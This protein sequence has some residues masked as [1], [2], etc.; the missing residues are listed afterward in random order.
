MLFKFQ[1][2]DQKEPRFIKFENEFDYFQLLAQ[3]E[4]SKDSITNLDCTFEDYLQMLEDL[5]QKKIQ[6]RMIQ[7]ADKLLYYKKIILDITTYS[8]DTLDNFKKLFLWNCTS[9]KI[10]RNID[11]EVTTDNI[12]NFILKFIKGDILN[13]KN[14]I[15]E[16][17]LVYHINICIDV[18][19]YISIKSGFENGT[20][21][22]LNFEKCK[23]NLMAQMFMP[24][25]DFYLENVNSDSRDDN[26]YKIKFINFIGSL[27]KNVF[28]FKI[29][30]I[31]PI[32]VIGLVLLLCGLIIKGASRPT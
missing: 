13:T 18:R 12:N 9:A 27:K 24:L 8:I 10:K 11:T 25:L 17:F 6:P 19:N 1:F 26:R 3:M 20:V 15:E 30:V 2:T 22:K 4:D 28:I 7:I 16:I 14:E 29:Y 32:Y 23:D 21:A 31:D 5:K